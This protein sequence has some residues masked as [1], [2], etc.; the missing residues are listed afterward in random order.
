M[1]RFKHCP[2]TQYWEQRKS[3]GCFHLRLLPAL[4]DGLCR[5]GLKLLPPLVGEAVDDLVDAAGREAVLAEAGK[6]LADEEAGDI[7]SVVAVVGGADVGVGQV[8]VLHERFDN[9]FAALDP[10]FNPD[11]IGG[12]LNLLEPGEQARLIVEVQGRQF[13]QALVVQGLKPFDFLLGFFGGLLALGR[14]AV[15]FGIRFALGS[16]V[17]DDGLRGGGLVGDNGHTVELDGNLLVVLA[18][19]DHLGGGALNR[20]TASD[21]KLFQLFS[22]CWNL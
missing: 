9:A 12:R 10:S 7:V 22:P 19:F 1:S 2:D 16:I 15:P 20:G 6:A 13:G 18:G 21:M 5:F 8:T 14:V 4:R 3:R 11:V 17:G